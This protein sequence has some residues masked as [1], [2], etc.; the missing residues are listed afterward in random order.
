MNKIAKNT[1]YVGIDV[2]MDWLDVHVLPGDM[3]FRVANTSRGIWSLI[4]KLGDCDE[5]LVVLEASGGFEARALET[6]S[7]AGIAVAMINP[8]QVRSFA[9]ALGILA[10]T[11]RIDAF[12]IARYAEAVKPAPRIQEHRDLSEI[13]ALMT[14]RRQLTE[15]LTEEKDRRCRVTNALVRR[16]LLVSMRSLKKEIDLIDRELDKMVAADKTMRARETLLR[17]VPGVGKVVARSLIAFV[18]ELGQLTR[19]QIA[20]LIGVAPF[21]R[22]SG[23]LKGRRTIWAGR[24][25][26]RAVLYMGALVA[27][28]C[29]HILSAFYDQLIARGKRPKVALTACMRKLIT[30]LNAMIRTGKP[31]EEQVPA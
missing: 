5:P 31:W 28:K 12:A 25:N 3:R 4:A 6:L 23:T 14:R 7:S 19:R 2:S 10:K 29:N 18:P 22:D 8:R 11:D 26:V 1:H 20:S 15:M 16:R 27:A 9:R 13:K 30:I 17:S 21:N 24:A